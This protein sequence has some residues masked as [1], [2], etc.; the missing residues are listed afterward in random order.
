MYT[1]HDLIPRGG[2]NAFPS[3]AGTPPDIGNSLITEAQ[4]NSS[5][6]KMKGAFKVTG[7]V[8]LGKSA[9]RINPQ[10]DCNTALLH[11]K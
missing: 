8:H 2:Q 6:K 10:C 9:C 1:A 5:F 3:E 7:H 4:P 11:G